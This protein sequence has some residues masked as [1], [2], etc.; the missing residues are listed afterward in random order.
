MRYF[1]LSLLA[2]LALLASRHAFAENLA[3]ELVA[4]GLTAPLHV[5]APPGDARLFAVEQTGRV[6]IIED[7]R[8][9]ERPFLDISA[10]LRFGGERGLLSLAFHPN[11]AKNGYI[12]VNY[13][14]MPLRLSTIVGLVMSGVWLLYMVRLLY[15]YFTYQ[16][17]QGW[18]SLMSV[19]LLFSGAQ[20]VLLGIIGEYLG[21]IHLTNNRKPQFV[22]RETIVSDGKA[23][24][25]K[26][27][28]GSA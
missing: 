18:A 17:P 3:V 6:L 4:R 12:F 14:V 25:G 13:S 11:Y 9:R 8:L 28:G 15:V 1:L 10:R 2:L 19:L 21:R 27:R 7:G 5:T 20:L 26:G 22:V 23:S 16:T 24:G